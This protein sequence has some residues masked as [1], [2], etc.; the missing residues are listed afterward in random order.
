MNARLASLLF[1]TALT[2]ITVAEAEAQAQSE[3]PY[4]MVWA[5]RTQDEFPP[6]ID[7]EDNAKWNVEGIEGTGTLTP[8]KERLLWGQSTGKLTYRATGDN[9]RLR[10]LLSQPVKINSSFDTVTCWV[11]GNK[12]DYEKSSNTSTV[13]I[14]ALFADNN[15]QEVEVPLKS[16]DYN[17]WFLLHRRLDSTLVT[18]LSKGA[19]FK[20]FTLSGGSNPD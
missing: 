12:F 13:S 4:E 14:G 10:V 19:V 11:Y 1:L 3:R 2:G 8:S 9:L 16:I 18:R 17:E 5:N 20:G 15:G 6:L 7:F